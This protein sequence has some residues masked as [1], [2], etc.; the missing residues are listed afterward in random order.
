MVYDPPTLL[1]GNATTMTVWDMVHDQV[2]F[3][4]ALDISAVISAC[5]FL[6]LSHEEALETISRVRMI[7]N[8]YR[9]KK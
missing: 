1:P 8:I 2:T 6:D 9:K 7:G 3:S 4:G 5:Q